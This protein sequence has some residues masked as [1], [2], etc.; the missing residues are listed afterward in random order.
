MANVL[1]C[2]SS[3]ISC[4]FSARDMCLDIFNPVLQI[5]EQDGRG[6]HSKG[7][8]KISELVNVRAKKL[9]FMVVCAQ[10]TSAMCIGEQYGTAKLWTSLSKTL[11]T[12][13]LQSYQVCADCR[14][15][16]KHFGVLMEMCPVH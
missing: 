10:V 14:I 12:T 1:M 13:K 2:G 15:F 3:N 9:T 16:C 7:D 11:Q 4:A 8:R 6:C 5:Q